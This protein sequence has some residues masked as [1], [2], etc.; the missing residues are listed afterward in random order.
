MQR[1]TSCR[2]GGGRIVYGSM[3]LHRAVQ[4][5]ESNRGGHGEE[6]SSS[7]RLNDRGTA[8]LRGGRGGR[9][10]SADNWQRIQP[11]SIVIRLIQRVVHT[12][13]AGA[14]LESPDTTN[15]WSVMADDACCNHNDTV[16]IIVIM[17][18]CRRTRCCL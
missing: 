12:R 5:V 10:Q 8:L 18:G 15:N 2:V 9:L 4:R 1:E 11:L 6:S 7:S 17:D 16:V 3:P 14:R 13:A